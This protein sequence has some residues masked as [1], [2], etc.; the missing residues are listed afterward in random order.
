MTFWLDWKDAS[1]PLSV[2]SA[3]ITMA[4]IA[5]MIRL[6]G[7]KRLAFAILLRTWIS[8]PLA[9]PILQFSTK[10]RLPIDRTPLVLL[11]DIFVTSEGL[12]S[13]HHND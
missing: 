9:S 6:Y 11:L 1:L 5:R 12:Q 10:Y 4:A 7:L 8:Y 3:S 2:I 13:Y